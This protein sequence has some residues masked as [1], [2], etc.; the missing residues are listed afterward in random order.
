MY[1]RVKW[2]STDVSEVMMEAVRTS[3]TSIHSNESTRS[4]IPQDSKLFLSVFRIVFWDVLPFK[5]IVDRNF[6]GDDGDST[7]LWNVGW[8]SFHTAVHPRR[9][10][11]TSYSPPWELEISQ[12]SFQVFQKHF[13]TSFSYFPLPAYVKTRWFHHYNNAWW[14]I[15]IKTG[16][17]AEIVRVLFSRQ[18]V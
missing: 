16:N 14:G 10:F 5:M 3:E 4:Y 13:F 6:R 1:S 18:W 7:H 8:Q 12:F 11:W 2:L 15:Q 9:Q 17:S